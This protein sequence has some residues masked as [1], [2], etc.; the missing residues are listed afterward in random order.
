MKFGTWT[1]SALVWGTTTFVSAQD[2]CEFVELETPI[3]VDLANV[4]SLMFVGIT[5]T[6]V[7]RLDGPPMVKILRHT[8]DRPRMLMEGT[9][10]M[11]ARADCLTAGTTLT[12]T[13]APA[14]SS[15]SNY[16]LNVASFLGMTAGSY[17]TG[18][19][20]AASVGFG[21]AA[22]ATSWMPGAKVSFSVRER[23]AWMDS[24]ARH[25]KSHT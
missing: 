1:L 17:L 7:T 12:P 20:P 15:S 23:Y 3:E 19:S 21:L 11:I 2:G 5:P 8:N 4:E 6:V 24:E 25:N 9:K 10:A 18:V 16:Y 22:T 14:A 13:T